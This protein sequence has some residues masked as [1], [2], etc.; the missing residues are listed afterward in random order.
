MLDRAFIDALGG[1]GLPLSEEFVEGF[2]FQL[3]EAPKQAGSH[4]RDDLS[5]IVT[6]APCSSRNRDLFMEGNN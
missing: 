6:T 4:S 3:Q 5:G 2:G 1:A